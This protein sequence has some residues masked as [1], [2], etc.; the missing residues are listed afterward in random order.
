VPCRPVRVC[1]RRPIQ[2]RISAGGPAS[3]IVARMIRCAPGYGPSRLVRREQPLRGAGKAAVAVETGLDESV[4]RACRGRRTAR[5]C[6]R[7]RPV[8]DSGPRSTGRLKTAHSTRSARGTGGRPPGRLR[9]PATSG[10]VRSRPGAAGSDGRARRGS[11][12]PSGRRGRWAF[13]IGARRPRAGRSGCRGS[14][15]RQASAVARIGRRAAA[16]H[17]RGRSP[18]RIVPRRVPPIAS[19]RSCPPCRDRPGSRRGAARSGRA[20]PVR[21]ASRPRPRSPSGPHPSPR[22]GARRTAPGHRRAASRGRCPGPLPHPGADRRPTF[23]RVRAP[24]GRRAPGGISSTIA[25][26]SSSASESRALTSR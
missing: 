17:G 24:G 3:A 7:R 4:D 8:S 19:R 26:A 25:A 22:T 11:S 13:A 12:R 23:A 18:R 9:R 5:R 14:R 6:A 1:S 16:D 15:R 2:T 10:Q 21:G 20:R